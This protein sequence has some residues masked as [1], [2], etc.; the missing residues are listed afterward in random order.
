MFDYVDILNVCTY[1]YVYARHYPDH[2]LLLLLL[3][4]RFHFSGLL[5]LLLLLDD[6]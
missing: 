2:R 6:E 4:L 5:L 1:A 3:Q